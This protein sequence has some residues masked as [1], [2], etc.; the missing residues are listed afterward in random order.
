MQ[1]KP[2]PPNPTAAPEPKDLLKQTQTTKDKKKGGRGG[3]KISPYMS[4]TVGAATGINSLFAQKLNPVDTKIW[5]IQ[6]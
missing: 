3:E 4:Q 6:I 5:L 2:P 1:T